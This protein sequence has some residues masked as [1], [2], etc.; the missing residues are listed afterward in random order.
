M[1]L[2]KRSKRC[3]GKS[4]YEVRGRLSKLRLVT[5]VTKV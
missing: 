3:S 5:K 4:H 2:I 1:G